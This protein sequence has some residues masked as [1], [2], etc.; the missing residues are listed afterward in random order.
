MKTP[1]IDLLACPCCGHAA[2]FEQVIDYDYD[3]DPYPRIRIICPLVGGCGL[4]TQW[5]PLY[6][7]TYIAQEWNRRHNNGETT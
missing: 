3:D 1:S 5:R 6:D 4:S 7:A 2:E